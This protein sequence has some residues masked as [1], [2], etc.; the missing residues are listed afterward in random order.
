MDDIDFDDLIKALQEI[1]EVFETEIAPHA[2]NLCSKL[3][4]AYLRLISLKGQG[5]E[6]DQESSLSA[7]GIMTAIRRVLTSV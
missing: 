4:E 5:D 1:V 3:S 6:E 7:D 2:I